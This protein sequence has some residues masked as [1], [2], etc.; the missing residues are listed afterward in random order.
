MESKYQ[1]EARRR[2][3]RAVIHDDGP[4]AFVAECYPDGEIWLH[5]T[6]LAADIQHIETPDCGDVRCTR[7]HIVTCVEPPAVPRVAV[8]LGYE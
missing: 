1:A 5:K 3:P 8:E 6:E 4:F 7:K 2:W